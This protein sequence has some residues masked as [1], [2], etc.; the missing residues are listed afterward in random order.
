MAI[1]WRSLPVPAQKAPFEPVRY[2]NRIDARISAV[3]FEQ[4]VDAFLEGVLSRLHSL[5]IKEDALPNLWSEVLTERRDQKIARWR[6]LEALCG[7]DPD[8]APASMVEMLIENEARLG[9]MA[10][11][12]VAA[13]GRHS[14]TDVLTSILNLA[15]STTPPKVVVSVASCR[16]SAVFRRL[17]RASGLGRLRVSLPNLPGP[18]GGLG[19]HP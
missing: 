7:Y 19:N 13:A 11:E 9:G 10:L 14:T 16:H 1:P 2:L 3:E 4:K 15:K 6:K 5:K 17:K 18:S 8:E 12:E